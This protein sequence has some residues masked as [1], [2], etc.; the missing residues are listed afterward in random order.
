[1]NPRKRI[2]TPC[3]HDEGTGPLE[4]KPARH[5]PTQ[6]LVGVSTLCWN[7]EKILVIKRGRE[8]YKNYW[9]L[10]GGLVE[11][12]ETLSDAALREL[13][14]ETGVRARINCHLDTFDSI[15]RDM[16][17]R[18]KSH[19]VLTVFEADYLSG[20]AEAADDAL[21]ARWCDQGEITA[22]KM[23]PGTQERLLW[24][25]KRRKSL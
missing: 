5:Y 4:E 18:I 25:Y 23:T 13:A 14:E 11:L 22:L 12:G 16:N 6:P 15:Q 7:D 3:S 17:G 21:A 24:A 10:P 19:F 20:T 1:M 2:S 9:A 8:P